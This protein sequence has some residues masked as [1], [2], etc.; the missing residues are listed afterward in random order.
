M[1]LHETLQHRRAIRYYDPEKPLDSARVEEC[2]H[3]ATLAPTSS[4]MQLYRCY[5][6]TDPAV[7]AALTPACLGQSTISTAKEVVVFA[8]TPPAGVSV[9]I[10]S[11]P[12]SWRISTSTSPRR[13]GQ[14]TKLCSV[15]T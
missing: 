4:N 5:H 10:T 14:S 1:S 6:I 12:A 9:W 8:I 7:I 11:S 15:N 3:Q 2:L 13:S